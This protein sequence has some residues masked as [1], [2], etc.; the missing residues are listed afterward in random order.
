MIDVDCA[1]Q[2]TVENR[3]QSALPFQS[4]GC[5]HLV[6]SLTGPLATGRNGFVKLGARIMPQVSMS[7]QY[8][9]ATVCASE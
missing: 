3:V 7:L 6:K 9:L 5:S 4:R 8:D 2:G 1:Q